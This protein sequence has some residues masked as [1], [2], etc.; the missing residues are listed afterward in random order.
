MVGFLLMMVYEHVLIDYIV[1]GGQLHEVNQSILLDTDPPHLNLDHYRLNRKGG[2]DMQSLSLK[3]LE[4]VNWKP[5]NEVRNSARKLCRQ[6]LLA[7]ANTFATY[8]RKRAIAYARD[9]LSH[10]AQG[11]PSPL[12]GRYTFASMS[13]VFNSFPLL[14]EAELEDSPS[15][16]VL[17]GLE[18]LGKWPGTS[19]RMGGGVLRK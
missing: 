13:L 3:E 1:L 7:I 14:D 9:F 5:K 11:H 4:H 17:F 6:A 19:A 8:N 15:T 18:E 16:V 12:E 2:K 10:Q